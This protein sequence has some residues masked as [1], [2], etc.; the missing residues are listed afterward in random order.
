MPRERERRL[1]GKE[2]RPFV[3]QQGMEC[4]TDIVNDDCKVHALFI[5]TASSTDVS[6]P[7]SLSQRIDLP[8]KVLMLGRTKNKWT[9]IDGGEP[10]TYVGA[11]I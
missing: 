6:G 9:T 11:Q 3:W 2:V 8:A 7:S 10:H 5:S 1:R 4:R